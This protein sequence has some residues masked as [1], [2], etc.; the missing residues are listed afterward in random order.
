VEKRKE[1]ERK[2]Q[3]QKRGKKRKE[4][5]NDLVQALYNRIYEFNKSNDSH[6]LF[7]MDHR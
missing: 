2:K 4:K 3:K 5:E 1:M 6:L 7:K